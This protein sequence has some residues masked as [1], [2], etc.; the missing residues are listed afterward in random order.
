MS[1]EQGKSL[2]SVGALLLVIGSFVPFLGIV[3]F[4]LLMI[5]LKNLSDYYKDKGIF[6]NALYGVLFGIIGAAAAAFILIAVFFGGVFLGFRYGPSG[7]D[8]TGI[9]GNFVAFFGGILI[10][11]V[12]AFI[13][14]ILMALYLKKSFDLLAH[15]SGVGMFRTA[16]LLLL[17]GAIL[18]IILIG[19][20]LIF[21]AWILLTVAFFSMTSS[22]PPPAQAVPT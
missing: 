10:A 6:N 20:V 22:P 11:L 15:M 16:G 4:I 2:G 19:L 1:L 5:G 9:T 7:Q 12:V 17:I 14:Y 3:G 21:V 13:F 8:I 18:T